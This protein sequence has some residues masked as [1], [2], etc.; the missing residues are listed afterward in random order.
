ML[1]GQK[2]IVVMPAYNAARTL[3]KTYA[4]IPHEVV[5]EVILVDD[6]SHDNTADLARNL[7]IN[8][9]LV[10]DTNLGYGGNQKT[11][12]RV[13]LDRNADIVVMIHPDYQYTPKLCSAMSSLIAEGTFDCVL[14]SRILGV[15][16]LQG[17][18]PLYKFV[19]NR[20]L[21]LFQNMMLSY[22][23]SEYHTGYRAFSRKVLETLPLDRNDND[24][25]FDNQM[26]LQII[27]AGFRIGEIT[28]PTVYMEDSSSINFK[29][30]TRYGLEV[31]K[32]TLCY[33]LH[34]WKLQRNPLFSPLDQP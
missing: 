32:T 5:D 10:H 3:Q 33:R 2:V 13:A 8:Q 16:A 23:L 19:A 6:H 24:F 17:G 28:C 21:T 29:R 27:Y 20:I 14:G 1:K 26:L 22:K 15:G 25:I 12:Y 11:C 18:M 34:R 9:V 30:A 4:E 31:L 7:G